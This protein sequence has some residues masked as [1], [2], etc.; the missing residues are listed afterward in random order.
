MYIVL[1][2]G[3]LGSIIPYFIPLSS[4][5]DFSQENLFPESYVEEVDGIKIHYQIWEPDGPALG[6]ILLVHGL[7][8][9]TFSWNN[10]VEDLR[11]AGYE[12]VVVDLPGFGYSS[13]NPSVDHS[14]TNRSDL[15]WKLLNILEGNQIQEVL[16]CWVLAGH[17][18]GGGTVAAMAIANPART[19]ALV[20]VDG[21]LLGS[22]NTLTGL[23]LK[24]PPINR[25]AQV[26][27]KYFI[28]NKDNIENF[29]TSAYGRKPTQIEVLGY[30]NPLLQPGTERVLVDIINSASNVEVDSLME[31]DIPILGIWGEKDTWVLLEQ[32]EKINTRIPR[33]ELEVIP[34]AT[35]SPMET[36]PDEFN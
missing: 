34:G 17:S 28:I 18:M 35:H 8:G 3:I 26:A 24:Y 15:L 11:E 33:I 6:E 20:L 29:L 4:F 5:K 2:L 21:A 12:V 27:L 1:I 9:S 10:N 14:Q 16:D 32:G 31:V 7:G 22:D 23:A 13:R 36:H 25:W 30:L 19:K